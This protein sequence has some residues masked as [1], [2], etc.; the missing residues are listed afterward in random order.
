MDNLTGG[1]LSSIKQKFTDG[2]QEAK[3]TVTGALDNIKSAFQEKLDAAHAVVIGIVD[4]IKGVFH[5][6]WSLPALKL[7]HV[8][9]TGGV[10][11]FGIAGK[12]SLPQFSVEWYAHGGVMTKPTIFGAAGGKLLGG[13][14]AGAEAILPLSALWDKLGAFLGAIFDRKEEKQ[15]AAKSAFEDPP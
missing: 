8:S 9:V 12:G 10:A 2:L 3:N 5:F 13:G 7:P 6:D 11:P 15:G 4:K 14:E 1:K